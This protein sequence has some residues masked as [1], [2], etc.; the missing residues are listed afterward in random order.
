MWEWCCV[1]T[2]TLYVYFVD[3]YHSYILIVK[4]NIKH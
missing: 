2:D 3:Q 4:I 1:I